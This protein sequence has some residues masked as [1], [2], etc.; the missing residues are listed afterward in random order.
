M[1]WGKGRIKPQKK[2]RAI[3]NA[4]KEQYRKIKKGICSII[5]WIIKKENRGGGGCE[6]L[7]NLLILLILK[8]VVMNFIIL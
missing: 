3:H 4:L 5:G 8:I 2:K 7:E 1:L 6:I